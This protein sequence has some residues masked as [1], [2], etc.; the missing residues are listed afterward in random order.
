M[1][2]WKPVK[3]PVFGS[4]GRQCLRCGSWFP[5]ARYWGDSEREY[6][7]SCSKCLATAQGPRRRATGRPSERPRN[8]STALV[9]QKA[10]ARRLVTVMESAQRRN[11]E[12]TDGIVSLCEDR[13]RTWLRGPAGG[14][15]A[16]GGSRVGE[17]GGAGGP[18]RAAR[19]RRVNRSREYRDL[20]AGSV[21]PAPE[22]GRG[23]WPLVGRGEELQVFTDALAE[24]VVRAVLVHGPA[25]V[26]KSRLAEEF[27]RIA[28]SAGLRSARVLANSGAATVPL[29]ALA[30]LLPPEVQGGSYDPIALYGEVSAAWR[31]RSRDGPFALL[32]DDLPLLDATSQLL[33][34]QLLDAGVVLLI[35]TVRTGPGLPDAVSALGRREDVLRFD[36]SSLSCDDVATLLHLALE[37]PV[38]AVAMAQIWD[39]SDGNAL[40]VREL[41]L[42]ARSAGN[43]VERRGAWS[44][45]GP[46]A[47]TARVYELVE[48][49]IGSLGGSARMA[50][51][52]LALWEPLGVQALELFAGV[53]ALEAV[54]QADLVDVR[55]EGRRQQ[56]SLGH[57][58]FGEVLRGHLSPLRRRRL[59]LDGADRIEHDGARRREDPL[60]IATSRLDATGSADPALLVAGARLARYGADFPTMERLGRAAFTAKASPEAALLLGDAL[61]N[62]G[63]P[64]ANEEADRILAFGQEIAGADESMLVELTGL[65]CRH[66][67]ANLQRPDEA[68]E[69]NRAIRARPH[70]LPLEPS[71]RRARSA[72]R[73]RPQRRPP[74]T[75]ADRVHAA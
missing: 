65:R 48:V 73:P 55:L 28:S 64:A 60:R 2:R 9:A 51:D 41:V 74:H 53:D 20:M 18:G 45:A 17:V 57:P 37:A 36:L 49:R 22:Q 32:V 25:G 13:S 4:S 8:A 15:S 52:F 50:L 70:P 3:Q 30:H 29:G 47:T 1:S 10:T 34:S 6:V 59:L 38:D 44:L 40:F 24:G 56:V 69:V 23:G 62:L 35:G 12:L 5:W 66:L 16:A 61:H 14:T 54:D 19:P 42:G 21:P 46:L 75:G 72:R 63:G 7:D 31:E 71:S 43:L 11:A 68:L 26:G 58:L 39:A 33:V 27:L 67:M